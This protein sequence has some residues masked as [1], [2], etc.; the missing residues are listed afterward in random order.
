MIESTAMTRRLGVLVGLLALAATAS[1][2]KAKP[3][4][5]PAKASA[6]DKAPAADDTAPT[7][8]DGSAADGSDAP[9]ALPDLPHL[10]GPKLVDL[11]NN[12]EIELP[13]GLALYEHDAAKKLV[14]AGGGNGATTSAVIFPEDLTQTWFVT[15]DFADAGYVTDTD[16]NELDAGQLLES[17]RQAT[18]Q[19]NINRKKLGVPELFVDSWSEP[20]RYDK[21]RHVLLWGL[22]AHDSSGPVIN[23]FTRVLGREGFMSVNLVDSP[24]KLAAAKLASAAAIANTRF[25]TGH[26]YEDH[27]DGDKSSGMGLKALVVGG[28]GIAVF[29]AAKAGLLIKFFKPILAG[30][31]AIGAF[32]KRLF[33]GKKNKV[34]LPPDG[35]PSVG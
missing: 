30:L 15:I 7:P 17:Y 20:P 3:K 8:A 11:G 27:K 6:K 14:E 12:T 2:D 19:D 18:N 34:Q 10:S 1:A 9:P 35:P 16:A 26:K 23:Y 5:A 31:V 32:F 29:K 24:D 33:T 28:A 22:N 21:S 4:A 25:K 13:A